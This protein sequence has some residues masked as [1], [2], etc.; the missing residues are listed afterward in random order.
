MVISSENVYALRGLKFG[1]KLQIRWHAVGIHDEGDVDCGIVF[2][3]RVGY[4]DGTDDKLRDIARC[5]ELGECYVE[6]DDIE[7]VQQIHTSHKKGNLQ[8]EK[9]KE[10][11]KNID[12]AVF[13]NS[14]KQIIEG[15]LGLRCISDDEEKV[16]LASFVNYV[17]YKRLH[18][19]VYEYY[20]RYYKDTQPVYYDVIRDF[21]FN[22]LGCNY[23]ESCS[24]AL[25]FTCKWSF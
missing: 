1:A 19:Y 16:Y 22:T 3:N 7:D 9:K 11:R 2:G 17:C 24:F 25:N 6:L 15:A 4:S 20:I 5:V 8:K 18:E 14:C 10:E 21:V 13:Q 23:K 12:F